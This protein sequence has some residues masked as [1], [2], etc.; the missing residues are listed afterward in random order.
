METAQKCLVLVVKVALQVPNLLMHDTI[1]LGHTTDLLGKVLDL[2]GIA[3]KTAPLL[4][5]NALSVMSQL[6]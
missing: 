2:P 4:R 5:N 3:N 6:E 1:L